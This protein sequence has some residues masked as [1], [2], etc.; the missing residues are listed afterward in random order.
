MSRYVPL[1]LSPHRSFTS[2]DDR[3]PGQ[4]AGDAKIPSVICYTQD[5][6]VEAVG[7]EAADET[8]LVR[9]KE[10]GLVF[11]ERSEF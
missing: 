9:V 6:K 3:F 7:A 11:V 4:G 5:G 10:E 2:S 8:M 1:S